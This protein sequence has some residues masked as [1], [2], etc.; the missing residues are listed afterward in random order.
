MT[1]KLDEI[2]LP[3]HSLVHGDRCCNDDSHR[4]LIESYYRDI[5]NAVLY[6]DG[7]LPRNNPAVHKPYWSHSISQ[8]K[9]KSIDC[10][11]FWR[12]SGCPKSGPIF[13]CKKV[14]TSNY[15]RAVRNAERDHDTNINT[16]LHENLTSLDSDSFWKVWR[17]QNKQVDSPV[18]RVDGE[19]SEGGIAG[20]FRNHFRR[21]Y[22][23]HST[24]AHESL[25]SEFHDQ[26][27][28][29]YGSHVHDS[30][31]PFYLS[32]SDMTEVLGKLKT[33]K[34]SAGSIRPERVL[35]GSVKLALHLHLLFNSMIQ[36]G[37]VVGD[38]LKGTITPIIKDSEGDVSDSSNYRGITLGG[39]FSKLFES[40][41]DLKI[42]PYLGSD[43]LQ[44]GFKKRTSTSHALFTL[45]STVD[46]FNM[47]GS[48]VFVGFLD[49]TK[50]FDRISHYGLFIKLMERRIPLCLLLIIIFWHINMS[51]RVKWGEALSEEFNVPL[52]TKQG[53]ISSPKF[54]SVYID[55]IVKILRNSGVGCHL[56]DTFVGCLLFADD[57]ALLAPTRSAL[58]NMINLCSAYC[59]KF[60]LQ[61]NTKKSKVMIFGKSFN[62]QCVPLNICGYPVDFTNEWKYLGTTLV[63]GKVL[64]HTARP[65]LSSFF[66]ATNAVL[67]VLSGAHEQILLTL[68]YANCVP[69]L[70]YACSVKNYSA[71]DMSDCNLA[72]NN[73]LRKVFG[74]TE[75]ESIRILREIFGFK[76]IYFI[77]KKV[78]DRFLVSCHHHQN[79]IISFIASI[80]YAYQQ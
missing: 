68:L 47:R 49:C 4:A 3:I 22:S 75:W 31:S 79:P 17:N 64:S 32:W 26:F 20:A 35:H 34:S 45:K 23:N 13:H 76:S 61:F 33:G 72:I 48:D 57:L 50:A 15:K 58:Q 69:I 21:V 55:D 12:S 80:I 14:C 51:C 6:S 63:S 44:F 38:F 65:D 8:L 40:A 16:E 2:V 19:T 52:G 70:T 27:A 25:K 54:F 59:D 29:Y 9:Q 36:H 5:E 1:E 10:C 24:P 73:A 77:F 74:F 60:C 42:S 43:Y 53:G 7:F 28:A 30:I 62:A 18:T 46:Y 78:Q 67:N 66:R 41:I 11:H 56:I 39:L 71:S 37:I